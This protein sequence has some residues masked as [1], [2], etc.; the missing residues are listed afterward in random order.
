MKPIVGF[1]G[2]L[3]TED[4]RVF[5]NKS[6]RFLSPSLNENGYLYVSL[7]QENKQHSFTVH[8][9]VAQAYIPNPDDKPYVNHI[10]ADRTNAHVSNLEWVTG[11]EN[12]LHAYALGNLSQKRHFSKAEVHWLLQRFLAGESITKLADTMKV[13]LSRLSINLRRH[14]KTVGTEEKF[15]EELQR[16]K[17]IRN[18]QA[19]SL[20]SQPVTQLS[21]DGQELA[22]FPSV[23]AAARALGKTSGG[24]IHNALNPNLSQEVAYGY[25]WKYS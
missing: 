11:S 15:K 25:L 6:N 12:T 19:N 3:V 22:S 23:N 21:L 8:R 18:Q 13:G 20:K 24:S 2:Y 4:G 10:D 7:W 1:D 9:L 14:A 17:T 16:Q 5:S